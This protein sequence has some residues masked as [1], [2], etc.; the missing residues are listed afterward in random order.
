MN[1][2]LNTYSE[3]VAAGLIL[4]RKSKYTTR[5][6]RDLIVDSLFTTGRTLSEKDARFI[7]KCSAT[8]H[9]TDWSKGVS[10]FGR[11]IYGL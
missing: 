8:F 5:D 9:G 2:T 1:N 7:V 6:C 11:S 10:D 4:P 3:V